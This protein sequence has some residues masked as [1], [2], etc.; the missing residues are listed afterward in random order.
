L[1]KIHLNLY[2]YKL[3]ESVGDESQLSPKNPSNALH[4]GKFDADYGGQLN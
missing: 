3:S 4:R 1:D 2:F